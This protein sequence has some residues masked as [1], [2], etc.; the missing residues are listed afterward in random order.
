MTDIL[1]SHELGS[2]GLR[3]D[4]GFCNQ[5]NSGSIRRYERG[6]GDGH[7]RTS[8]GS[9]AERDGGCGEKITEGAGVGRAPSFVRH[10][11]TVMLAL[12]P[13]TIFMDSDIG[14]GRIEDRGKAQMVGER[15]RSIWRNVGW[16][17]RKAWIRREAVGRDLGLISLSS[18]SHLGCSEG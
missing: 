11:A 9:G 6:C 18:V 13:R 8:P 4:S 5:A 2:K 14:A 1:S 7:C 3:I 17:V 15:V 12:V 16:Y 10:T